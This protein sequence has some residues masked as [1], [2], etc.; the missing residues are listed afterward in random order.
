MS[1]WRLV[2]IDRIVGICVTPVAY[3]KNKS[4][5]DFKMIYFLVVLYILAYLDKIYGV[6]I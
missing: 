3:Y 1:L 2:G 5:S 6:S 4:G